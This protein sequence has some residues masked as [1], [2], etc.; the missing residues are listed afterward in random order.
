M[1]VFYWLQELRQ[2]ILESTQFHCSAGISHS[3]TLSK[4]ACGLNKPRKQTILP[5]DAVGPLFAKTNITDVRFLGG[6]LGKLIVENLGITSMGELC[7]VS[8][9]NL[10]RYFDLK[11]ADWLMGISE[12]KDNESVQPRDQPKSIGCSKNFL[13]KD[14]LKTREEVKMWMAH[15]ATELSV[16]LVQLRNGPSS[17][18]ILFAIFHPKNLKKVYNFLPIS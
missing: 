17:F 11:T 15:F 6:K 7:K 3:K 10:L 13:G 4:L 18:T 14:A 8:K 1:T 2:E 5:T 9:S 16:S 12:G